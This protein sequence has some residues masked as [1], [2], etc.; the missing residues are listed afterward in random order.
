MAEIKITGNVGFLERINR[1][2]KIDTNLVDSIKVSNSFNIEKDYIEYHLLDGISG[3]I[4][5]SDYNYQKYKI[6][7]DSNINPDGT[8]SFV[9]IDPVADAQGLYSSGEFKALYSVFRHKISNNQEDLF[10]KE[11]SDD[12]TEIRISSTVLT[13]DQIVKEATSLIKEINDSSYSNYFLLNFKNNI[14]SVAVNVA[15]DTTTENYTILFKL[16]EPLSNDIDVKST[17]WVVDEIT[18]PYL[19]NINLSSYLTV[20]PLP[21]LR[22]PNFSIKVPNHNNVSTEYESYSTV[23]TSLSG[24]DS[25]NQI[26]NYLSNNSA[27]IN[28]D[29][30]NFSDFVK[31]SSVEKR[32]KAFYNKVKTIEDYKNNINVIGSIPSSVQSSEITYYSSSI[33]DIISGFDGFE[34]YMYFESSSLAYP[35]TSSSKPYTL[36]PTASVQTWYVNLLS[37]AID[38][39][40]ENLDNLEYTVPAYIRENND[41]QPYLDFVHMVGHYFDNI[42]IYLKSVTDLHKSNNNIEEGVS[43]D[44]VYYAL[45][46]LGVNLYNSKGNESLDQMLVGANSGSLSNLDNIPKQDLLAESYKRIYHNIPLLFKSKGTSRGIDQL[47]N[48]FG[49]PNNILSIKEFGGNPKNN[50]LIGYNNDKINVLANQITGSVLSPHIRLEQETLEIANTKSVDYHKLDVSFSPQNEI[51]NVLS[52]SISN[53]ITGFEIDNYIGDPRLENSGSYPSLETLRKTHIDSEFSEEFDYSGFVE[54]VKFFD[55]SLFKMV[56]DYTPGRSNTSVG[57]T[58]RPQHL[59]R[60]KIKRTQPDFNKQTVYDAEFNGPVISEDSDYLYNLLPNN[61]EAFY[62]GELSGSWP[63]INEDFERTNPNPFLVTTTSGSYQ[64]EHTDFNVTLNNALTGRPAIKVQKLMPLYSYVSGTLMRTGETQVQTDVQEST[65][66]SKSFLLSRYE[67]VKTTSLNY[68]T[69]TSSSVNYDGDNSYGKTA[70]ID[71]QVRKLGLFSEIVKS[72]FLPNRNDV[73]TKYLVD[74]EGNLTELNQR[75]KNWEEIQRTFIS[76]DYLNVS[77]FDNQ[78]YSNQKSLDGAKYIFESG[79]SYTPLLYFS[80]SESNLYFEATSGNTSRELEATHSLGL[81]TSSVGTTPNYPLYTSGSSKVVYNVF[82]DVT[83][84]INSLSYYH[85][86]NSAGQTFPSYSVPETGLYNI[87]AS[88]S[89]DVTMSDGGNVTW[90]LEIVSGGVVLASAQKEVTIVDQITGSTYNGNA[91]INNPQGNYNYS[92]SIPQYETPI[93]I[94]GQPYV[95]ESDIVSPSG[96]VIFHRGQKIYE[97]N[98][99]TSVVPPNCL[100]CYNCSC[101]ASL[102]IPKQVWSTNSSVTFYI[103]G[104]PCIVTQYYGQTQQT[105][106]YYSY[107][108]TYLQEQY[109]EIPG[110]NNVADSTSFTLSITTQKNL[111]QGDKYEIK[112]KQNGLNITGGGNYI[113]K[114]NSNGF[115]RI[116]SISNQ[117]N[118]LPNAVPGGTGFIEAT[119]FTTG[120][121]TSSITL[122]S[123]LSSFIGY[124]F[125]PNPPTGSGL[126]DNLLY[127]IYGDVDNSFNPSYFDLI[128]HHNTSGQVNEYRIV[129]VRSENS[130]VILDIFPAFD[131][132]QKAIQFRGS[133]EKILFLKRLKDETNTI[134]NFTK[135]DGKTS[136]GFIVPENIHPEVFA[137]IDTITR[138]VKTKMIEGGGLDG[139]II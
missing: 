49:I 1:Y 133:L 34:T 113:A 3:D 81:I 21:V 61:K 116:A 35:K 30:T 59:E 63:D 102:S 55:N 79:Y 60:I 37:S 43:K 107:G 12:R 41:N 90:S 7:S 19:F 5:N 77:L 93:V 125:I 53:V 65:L 137:N 84:D 39:D 106:G 17:L 26:A 15:L 42:W 76:D 4:L 85:I 56:K 134:I 10:I 27:D 50:T 96:T 101:Q 83:K 51:D 92:S 139:G 22:G 86:G 67:G 131:T 136:Y 36:Q 74:E 52:S 98:F 48:I 68:N 9:E 13:N 29:Y 38:Y 99:Y 57:V 25:Y 117:V 126:A 111:T 123:Q 80:G 72:K 46:S 44:L 114:F 100:D 66:G 104:G 124:N 135:R 54:L 119:S 105:C 18:E 118:Q 73:I 69:Y 33:S 115:L 122:N 132:A 108:S 11:I 103:T 128:V 20:D 88:V 62:T 138:E 28:I 89:L 32:I 129:N 14:V 110:I 40:R 47:L 121:T 31:F 6:P 120:S 112:L 58:I 130:K 2:S 109:Y 87:T 64:F 78:K 23:Y 45:K 91:Y 71:K 75:N 97:Y 70:T 82:T 16:Y 24:S 94:Y 127:P 95:L 8:Y